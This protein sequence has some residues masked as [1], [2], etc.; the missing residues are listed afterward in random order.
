MGTDKCGAQTMTP[1]NR[2]THAQE[3]TP[4]WQR[5]DT[6]DR[7]RRAEACIPHTPEGRTTSDKRPRPRHRRA[8]AALSLR[9]PD[10]ATTQPD[11]QVANSVSTNLS[12]ARLPCPP[13]LAS[14]G[15]SGDADTRHHTL[16]AP[17]KGQ[18]ASF[19]LEAALACM[20]LRCCDR[21][22]SPSSLWHHDN[23]C[24]AP[25][26]HIPQA[27]SL[28]CAWPSAR[29]KPRTLPCLEIPSYWCP[30]SL[31]PYNPWLCDRPAL[32]T[33]TKPICISAKK[34]DLYEPTSQL[35]IHNR[36][37][38]MLRAGAELIQK[39]N[40]N[41]Y[42]KSRKPANLYGPLPDA[43]KAP[44]RLEASRPPRK[45]WHRPI[46][47][48]NLVLSGSH[49]SHPYDPSRARSCE[50]EYCPYKNGESIYEFRGHTPAH[51]NPQLR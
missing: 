23:G 19:E 37:P 17:R 35:P 51:T 44:P 2:D 14:K 49:T 34:T 26:R 10:C 3:K 43:R 4:K 38:R 27:W 28:C 12:P 41:I 48:T 21:A 33:H 11:P 18:A 15:W 5:L 32:V 50:P 24:C 47:H 39:T 30:A 20:A 7:P 1:P 40:K 31:L 29:G 22:K 36:V 9:L 16:R 42:T 8:T 45:I 25:A 13:P 6:T 46:P